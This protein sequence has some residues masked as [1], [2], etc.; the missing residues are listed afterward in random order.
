MRSGSRLRRIAAIM[1]RDLLI[2]RSYSFALWFDL[3][4][5]LIELF[6]YFFVSRTFANVAPA[7]LGGAPTYFAFVAVGIVLTLV[8]GAASAGIVDRIRSEQQVGTLETLVAQPVGAVDLCVGMIGYPFLFALVRA[9]VY[10]AAAI[11]LLGLRLPHASWIGFVA[12]LAA[13]SAALIAIGIAL[14]AFAVVFK[15]GGTLSWGVALRL[16][17]PAAPISRSPSF[18]IGFGR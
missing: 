1:R 3:G 18:P 6:I 10:S 13:A 14:A 9:A 2:A 7:S 16:G 5:G 11:G 4:F 12:V 17:L 8:V 15:R